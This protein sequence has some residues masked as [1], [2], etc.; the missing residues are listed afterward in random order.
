VTQNIRELNAQEAEFL[1]RQAA[2]GRTIF[3][4]E[5][6]RDFWGDAA[7]TAKMLSQLARKRWLQRLERSVYMIIPLEAGPE[8]TWSEN[9]LVIVPHLVQPAAVA[10]WSALHYWSLTEQV[11][12]TVF[13]QC[14]RRK[15]DVEILGQRFHFVTIKPA[16]FFGVLQRSIDGKSIS[17]TDREK[18]LLDTASRLDLSG[19]SR[20]LA[21]ALRTGQAALDWDRFDHYLAR[22]DEGAAVKRLGYLIE[23]L[24]LPLPDRGARLTKWQ[25]AITHGV[26]LLDP[27][28]A[29][30]G[31]VVT[32][33]H[34][35]INVDLTGA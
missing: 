30:A 15:R 2:E 16:R 27:S 18:T 24:E 29:Q 13:V 33:W 19:G 20:Q 21:A 10:Y 32:R 25:A 6:A 35:R 1:S 31:P 4:T 11:P 22:W 3:S 26:S 5:E 8:R 9:A 12:Q 34:L 14:T 23:A 7:Y 17:V 28:A